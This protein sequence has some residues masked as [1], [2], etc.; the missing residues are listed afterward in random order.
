MELHFA[1]RL[2]IFGIVVAI[3]LFRR[4]GADETTSRS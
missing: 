1:V 4:T 2:L 3:A